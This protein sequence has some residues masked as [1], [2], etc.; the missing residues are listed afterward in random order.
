[1]YAV[2]FRAKVQNVDDEYYEFSKE[3]RVLA[4]KHFHCV[5]FTSSYKQGVEVSVSY[6]DSKEDLAKWKKNPI[7]KK[8]Q[9]LGKERW[10]KEVH[11]EIAQIS[12]VK[13]IKPEHWVL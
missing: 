8:A 6:W 9:L 12:T 13:G 4:I 3:L 10:Y 1:M 7:H 2:F 11:T 5:E